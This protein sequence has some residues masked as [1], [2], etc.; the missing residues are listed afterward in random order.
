MKLLNFNKIEDSNIALKKE[1]E[2]EDYQY[3]Q[4]IH[5]L[6]GSISIRMIIS[7]F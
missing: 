7:F 1:E 2:K 3:H 4:S 5:S 6:K